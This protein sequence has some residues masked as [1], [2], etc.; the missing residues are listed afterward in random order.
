MFKLWD[1]ILGISPLWH[2]PDVTATSINWAG[3][4]LVAVAAAVLTGIAFI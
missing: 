2:V 1:W 3:L 4:A